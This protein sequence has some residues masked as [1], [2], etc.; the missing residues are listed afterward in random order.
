MTDIIMT[1]CNENIKNIEI[2]KFEDIKFL[3]QKTIPYLI[4]ENRN[5]SNE[6]LFL[7]METSKNN[8]T[9]FYPF[10]IRQSESLTIK[11][12]KMSEYDMLQLIKQDFNQVDDLVINNSV[13]EQCL[14][15]FNTNSNDEKEDY[16]FVIQMKFKVIRFDYEFEKNNGNIEKVKF[17]KKNDILKLPENEKAYILF[18]DEHNYTAALAI[19]QGLSTKYPY[20]SSAP[21]NAA[22]CYSK[23]NKHNEALD[24][25]RLSIRLGGNGKKEREDM[26]KDPDLENTRKAFPDKFKE[27]IKYARKL[28]LLYDLL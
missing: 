18:N 17:L 4:G 26:Q 10:V 3:E 7:L 9:I 8:K 21:Y 5:N 6:L 28:S 23:L 13:A 11:I 14:E 19:F 27:L 12:E 25:L 22:C 16:L 2:L 1:E 15:Y 24:N 20:T